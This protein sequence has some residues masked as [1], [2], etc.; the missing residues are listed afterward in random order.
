MT[1]ATATHAGELNV[2]TNATANRAL[3]L[4]ERRFSRA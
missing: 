4:I 2:A 3:T 1:T